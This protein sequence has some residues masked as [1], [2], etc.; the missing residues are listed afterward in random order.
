MNNI[1]S[2]VK[3]NTLAIINTQ[4][5]YKKNQKFLENITKSLK[6][7][8]SDVEMTR[9]SGHATK[10]LKEDNAVH[11]DVIAVGGDG[12]ILEVINGMDLKQQKLCVF[13]VGYAN[14]LATDLGFKSWGQALNAFE[15]KKLLDVDLIK[16]TIV[17]KDGETIE[18][19]VASSCSVGSF[20]QIRLKKIKAINILDKIENK[21]IL[22]FLHKPFK[23]KGRIEHSDWNET[24]LNNII[25]GNTR[26]IHRNPIFKDAD[27]KDNFFHCVFGNISPLKRFFSNMKL[28]P[29]NTY[30]G[31]QKYIKNIEFI[32][33][34]PQIIML[35]GEIIKDC[36]QINVEIHPEKLLCYRK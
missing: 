18:K 36:Q 12:T 9:Y 33:E 11:K 31:V 22:D 10:I 35:D 3:S 14:G 32:F 21:Q 17:D 1:N 26:Y 23:V 16:T 5:F 28:I 2:Q 4:C 27:L 13:P 25:I 29:L 20:N 30:Y 24:T 7:L 34:K 19:K 8:N 15:Q 6:R